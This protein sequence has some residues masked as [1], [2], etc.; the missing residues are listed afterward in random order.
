MIELKSHSDRTA[1][2]IPKVKTEYTFF[3]KVC[4]IPI[5]TGMHAHCVKL[6]LVNILTLVTVKKQNI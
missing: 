3:Q 1:L 5:A 2:I 6:S 4:E